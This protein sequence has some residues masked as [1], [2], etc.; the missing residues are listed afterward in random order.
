VKYL[1]ALLCAISIIQPNWINETRYEWKKDEEVWP[2]TQ[3]LQNISV[4]TILPELDE[5]KSYWSL[6]QSQKQEPDIYEIDQFQSISSSGRTYPLNI[7]HGRTNIL[8]KCIKNYSSIEDN[9][10]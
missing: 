10:F 5:E 3:K 2:V 6:E 8:Y 9:T 1:E 4:Q 7:P